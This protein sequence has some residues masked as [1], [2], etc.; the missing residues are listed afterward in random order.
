M[1]HWTP[2]EFPT[3]TLEKPTLKVLPVLSGVGLLSGD[4]EV[5]GAEEGEGLVVPLPP[6][7]ARLRIRA[8]TREKA[9]NRWMSFFM[10]LLPFLYFLLG[11]ADCNL[12][13]NASC[14]RPIYI[15]CIVR[16]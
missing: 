4:V 14:L 10:L 12:H 7:A 9:A 15:Y 13:K 3:Q 1:T 6:Q 2:Q 8:S 16:F 5:G 11:L